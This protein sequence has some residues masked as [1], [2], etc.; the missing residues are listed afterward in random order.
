MSLLTQLGI[1]RL[2]TA[3]RFRLLEELSESLD[4]EVPPLSEAQHRELRRRVAL[5][6]AD[7][8]IGR[9]WEEVK[10][11]VLGKLGR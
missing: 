5:M 11:R 10:A 1:D 4:A 8:S 9:P 2:D 3:A 7:P 6:D